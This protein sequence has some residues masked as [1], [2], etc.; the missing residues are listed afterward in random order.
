VNGD[1][2]VLLPPAEP[3][4]RRLPLA[5]AWVAALG[6]AV[7]GLVTIPSTLERRRL[8]RAHAALVLELREREVALERLEKVERLAAGDSFLRRRALARLLSPGGR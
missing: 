4:E 3:R 6:V 5:V 7:L 1:L 2:P 8:D